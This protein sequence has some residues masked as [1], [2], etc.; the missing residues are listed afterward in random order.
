MHANSHT[1]IG[2][3]TQHMYFTYMYS[4]YCGIDRNF[5]MH[6]VKRVVYLLQQS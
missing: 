1:N 3:P 4:V 2:R 5:L 6:L